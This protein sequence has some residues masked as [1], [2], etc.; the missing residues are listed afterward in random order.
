MKLESINRYHDNFYNTSY[1]D[2]EFHNYTCT[3]AFS[4]GSSYRR[5]IFTE[6]GYSFGAVKL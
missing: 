6:V 5:W 1:L 4:M 3:F 2:Y